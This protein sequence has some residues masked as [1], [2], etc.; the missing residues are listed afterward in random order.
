MFDLHWWP[1][2]R[3]SG[4]VWARCSAYTVTE[5]IEKFPSKQ[6]TV[7]T[8]EAN[9][10]ELLEIFSLASLGSSENWD[11]SQEMNRYRVQREA[12][13]LERLSVILNTYNFSA[14]DSAEKI[15]LAERI[16]VFAILSCLI[17]GKASELLH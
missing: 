16:E 3:C 9:L 12:E 15:P 6:W 17:E 14:L 11:V 1:R 13:L 5:T 8:I 2:S 4:G 10:G 7:G